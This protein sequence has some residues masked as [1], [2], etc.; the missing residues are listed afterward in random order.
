MNAPS[1]E[2]VQRFRQRQREAGNSRI[3]LYLDSKTQGRLDQL[4]GDQAQAPFLER[5]VK[6][7]VDREWSALVSRPKERQGQQCCDARH[8]LAFPGRRRSSARL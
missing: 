6:T 2:R 8:T 1:T 4:A 5:L 3:T 7:A